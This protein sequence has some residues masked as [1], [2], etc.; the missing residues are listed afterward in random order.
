VQALYH[1]ILISVTSFFRDPEAYQ[2]LKERVF[3][4][5]SPTQYKFWYFG[6][7]DRLIYFQKFR[8]MQ[9]LHPATSY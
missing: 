1:E 2:A 3:P 4:A 9:Q 5:I 6:Q 8:A 7:C